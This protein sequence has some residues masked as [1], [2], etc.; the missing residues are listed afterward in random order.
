MYHEIGVIYHILLQAHI[1]FG[2]LS[3]RTQV[4]QSLLRGDEDPE[5]CFRGWLGH[6][7]AIV[8]DP[9]VPLKRPYKALGW[10]VAKAPKPSLGAHK[11]EKT[12]MYIYIH[13][14]YIYIH[15]YEYIYIYAQYV[16]NYIN[17]EPLKQ[18]QAWDRLA[19]VRKAGLGT[20]GRLNQQLAAQLTQTSG[21]I[22]KGR[23]PDK[24]SVVQYLIVWYSRV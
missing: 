24:Y 17:T 19:L 20:A 14:I 18:A 2:Q 9:I 8:L 7:S 16:R 12:N 10:C 23:S 4:S 1:L 13:N 11:K 22:Q 21:R 5:S 15:I 3:I 6:V